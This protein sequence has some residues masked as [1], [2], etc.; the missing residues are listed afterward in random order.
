MRAGG[1]AAAVT[2]M[3]VLPIFSRA[4]QMPFKIPVHV[5][6]EKGWCEIMK[7]DKEPRMK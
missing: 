7:K 3:N 5:P 4:E 6:D 1:V 2:K